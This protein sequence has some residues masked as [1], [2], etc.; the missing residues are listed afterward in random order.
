[1]EMI[2]KLTNHSLTTQ[3]TTCV[4]YRILISRLY[5][6]CLFSTDDGVVDHRLPF[7]FIGDAV[8][9]VIAKYARPTAF[10]E[11]VNYLFVIAFQC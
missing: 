5:G 3:L 1:M 6:L 2:F 7:T 9:V 10:D 11:N 4:N 8:V